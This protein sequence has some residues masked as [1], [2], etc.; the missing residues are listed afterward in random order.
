MT[1]F[2]SI[3][4]SIGIELSIKSLENWRRFDWFSQLTDWVCHQTDSTSFRDG[5]V[6]VLAILTPVLFAVWLVAAMLGGVW[7]AFEFAFGVAVLSMSLGPSDPIRQTQ[8][9][10][11]SLQNEDAAEAKLHVAKI[12]D[13]DVSDV[14]D[15]ATVTAQQVK[16]ALLIKVCSSILGVFFW[17][18]VLGPVGAAMFRLSCLLRERYVGTE[19]GF[20]RAIKDFYQILMWLPARFTVLC[21]AVVGSFVETLRSLRHPSDLWQRDSD[22]LL[23]ETGLG[24]LHVLDATIEEETQVNIDAVVESLSLAKRAIL[25]CI[26]FLAIIVIVSWVV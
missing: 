26:T 8:D 15:D 21:Y 22:E 2:I 20:A 4:L 23:V 24:A 17:F 14:D 25:A 3:I 11:K 12:L 1:F 5:P 18:I 10:I 13:R 7:G 6:V 19:T 16:E 9:Y